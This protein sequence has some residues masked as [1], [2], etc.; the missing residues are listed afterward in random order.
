MREGQSL[1]L[2]LQLPGASEPRAYELPWNQ[3]MAQQLQQALEQAAAQRHR[4]PD[5]AAVRADAGRPRAQVL[6]APQPAMPPKDLA[7]PPAQIYQQPGQ[8]A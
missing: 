2:W 7:Q 5:A 8:N 4:G 6:R 1:Y 3:Q